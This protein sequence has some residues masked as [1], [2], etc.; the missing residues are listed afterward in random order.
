MIAKIEKIPAAKQTLKM[1][2]KTLKDAKTVFQSRIMPHARL[3]VEVT[4]FVVKVETP[5]GKSIPLQV[6]PLDTVDNVKTL[7]EQESG[8]PLEQ[9]RLLFNGKELMDGHQ[10][11]TSKSKGY[12]SLVGR[13]LMAVAT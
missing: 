5:T 3:K 12:V 9:Q 7:I 13:S 1:K 2:S 8:M 10:T 11:R 4:T 6:E